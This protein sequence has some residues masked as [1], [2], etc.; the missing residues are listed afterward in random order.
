[1]NNHEGVEAH[2]ADKSMSLIRSIGALGL[3][4]ATMDPSSTPMRGHANM[5]IMACA[6]DSV[7]SAMLPNNSLQT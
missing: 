7:I 6:H 5:V 2:H 1:M 4:D 3:L